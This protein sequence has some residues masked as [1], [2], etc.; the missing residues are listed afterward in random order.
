MKV[1][2]AIVEYIRSEIIPHVAHGSE[3]T[4]ALLSGILRAGRKR[5]AEKISSNTM[6]QSFGLLDSDG[7]ANPEMIREFAEGLF[8]GRDKISVSLA[9]LVKK[10]TGVDSDSD[11]LKDKL[12]FSREDAGKF[13]ELLNRKA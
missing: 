9:E 3:L 12:T 7:N 8:E 1:S 6:L 10:V 2:E 4:E 11:L 5:I 13:I